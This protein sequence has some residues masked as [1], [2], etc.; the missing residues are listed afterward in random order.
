MSD[1]TRPSWTFEFFKQNISPHTELTPQTYAAIQIVPEQV[2]LE[3][4]RKGVGAEFVIS[5]ATRRELKPT[6][7]RGLML[8]ITAINS[9]W[10]W[11]V[12][13]TYVD[14]FWEEPA[15]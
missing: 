4:R 9:S 1:L 11:A 3:A 14:R 15:A 8:R 5:G 2:P 12:P 10:V 6:V 13:A 7:E